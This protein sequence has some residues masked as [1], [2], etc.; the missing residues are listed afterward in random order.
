MLAWY[1][2]SHGAQI[3]PYQFADNTD[4]DPKRTR[5]LLLHKRE[6]EQLMV[7]IEQK[8][9]AMVPLYFETVGRTIKLTFGVG[10][11]L[12][13]YEKRAVIKKRDQERDMRR[14]LKWG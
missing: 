4:Y 8:K 12:K 9:R 6:I 14:E 5:K 11:G 7:D 10:R 13:Q 2:Q 1:N 3:N